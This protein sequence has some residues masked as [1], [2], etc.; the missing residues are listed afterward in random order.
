VRDKVSIKLNGR[1]YAYMASLK[2]AV[3]PKDLCSADFDIYVGN[4]INECEEFVWRKMEDFKSRYGNPNN[5]AYHY[6]HRFL[7][8]QEK[9]TMAKRLVSELTDEMSWYKGK[10]PL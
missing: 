5:K 8:E 9:W 1:S 7:P 3:S 4:T 10:N 6:V 2:D